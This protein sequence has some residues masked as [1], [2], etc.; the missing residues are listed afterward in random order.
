MQEQEKNIEPENKSE[1]QA[2]ESKEQ[3]PEKMESLVQWHFTEE[4]KERSKDK[5]M[6]II[7]IGIASAALAA[8][9]KTYIFSVMLLLATLT[10]VATHR[11]KAK[12]MLFNITNIGIFMDDDFVEIKQIKGFNIIDDPG[13]CARLILKV[14]KIVCMNEIVPIYDTNIEEIKNAL[15]QMD[16]QE[17]ADLK[18][19]PMDHIAALII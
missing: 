3:I 12:K 11:K 8:I 10:L 1:R 13:D 19:T 6:L 4:K 15:I 2:G 7:I 16:I 17:E 18:P 9:A 14:E 5:E